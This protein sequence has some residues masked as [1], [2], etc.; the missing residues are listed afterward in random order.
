MQ[1]PERRAAPEAKATDLAVIGMLCDTELG[2][3]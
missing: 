3:P 2:E 1:G